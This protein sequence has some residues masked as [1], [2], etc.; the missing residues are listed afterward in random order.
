M[1]CKHIA[2]KNPCAEQWL[3]SR[4]VDWCKYLPEQTPLCRT[5]IRGCLVVTGQ[6]A[7]VQD[8]KSP[9]WSVKALSP[10]CV[11]P[12]P[13]NPGGR[14]HP[15]SPPRPI[16]YGVT[17]SSR[18]TW[19]KQTNIFASKPAQAS[20][21]AL[22]FLSLQSVCKLSEERDSC[23]LAKFP[24]SSVER[25][26]FKFTS[27]KSRHLTHRRLMLTARLRVEREQRSHN[28]EPSSYKDRNMAGEGRRWK[29]LNISNK[30]A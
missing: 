15:P 30:I 7:D 24:Q 28:V 8:E 23:N 6:I 9:H 5:V 27:A 1:V 14:C 10:H 22:C 4:Q 17:C 21:T 3:L 29:G 16:S 26:I 11:Q 13:D 18:Y 25:P 12:W 2:K 20:Q 19:E